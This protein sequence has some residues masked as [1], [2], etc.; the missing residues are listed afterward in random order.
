MTDMRSEVARM[1]PAG[2]SLVGKSL[3]YKA[4][5]SIRRD[6][7]TLAA[8]GYIVIL[9][10]I[11]A[12]APLIT[13]VIMRVDPNEPA[14]GDIF[15]PPLTKGYLLGADDIGRDQLARLLHA[16]GVSM[17]IGFF[18]A[19]FSS[20][21]GVVLG[22]ITGYFG[23]I[24]DDIL[25]WII[26]TLDSIPPLFLLI[27]LSSVLSFSAQSLV[28][29]VTLIGWTGTTRL[30]RGQTLS[31][32]AKEYVLAAQAM[33]ANPFRILFIHILPNLVSITVVQLALGI[34]GLILAES[35]LSYLGLGV[36]PPQATWGNM[37]TKSFQFFRHGPHL[38]I[39]PILMIS[40]TVLCFY[41]IGDGIRDA[42]D[43]TLQR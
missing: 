32:R 38:I 5:Q 8:L 39:F 20:T 43:P 6:K 1:G 10:I 30:I 25:H 31:I 4:L 11:T 37:L 13:D 18:G 15:T 29:V 9:T 21:I 28:L 33:G 12:S 7:L 22:M 41:I 36:Q 24:T 17:A 35:G 3:T 14:T 26:T 40:V 34:A 27:L 19:L 42:F 16:G 23:G 2:Q